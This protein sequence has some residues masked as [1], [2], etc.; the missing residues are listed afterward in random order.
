MT[1]HHP[2]QKAQR[3]QYLSCYR[4]DFDQTLKVGSWDYLERISTIEIPF[5]HATFVQA[6][7]VLATFVHISNI[8]GV[9]DLIL[10]K[11]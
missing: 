9:A 2:T 10:T 6:T 7:S 5:I 4:P 3:Q 11:L 8:S 1:L